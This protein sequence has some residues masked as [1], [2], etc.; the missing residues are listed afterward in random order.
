MKVKVSYVVDV[1]LNAW[2]HEYGA[3]KSEAFNQVMT[4]LVSWAPLFLED[5]KWQTLVT[6]DSPG[7]HVEVTE[8]ERW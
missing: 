2:G 5:G 7:V 8:E 3:S 1:D 6:L 4:D